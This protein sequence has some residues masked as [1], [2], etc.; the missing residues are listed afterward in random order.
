MFAGGTIGM[1]EDKKTGVLRPA[2]DVSAILRFFPELRKKISF[3][4]FSLFNIDSSNMEPSHWSIV[5]RKIK[6]VYDRFDGFLVI[7]GT[8]TLAYTASALSFAL[9]NLSKPIVFTGSLVPLSELGADARNNLIYASL[10]AT[11]DIAEVCIVFGHKILRGNRSKKN[12]ESFV[13]VFDSPI[14]PQL[15]EIERPIRL[16]EW[17]RKRRKRILA[18][19]PKFET[20][21]RLVKIF[22]GFDPSSLDRMIQGGAKG[23]I[24]E[25]YGPGN[26]PFLENSILP[27]IERAIKNG[28][29]VV[30]GSQMEKSVTN[31]HAYEAGYKVLQ[32][33]AISA[34]DMT[35]ESTVAKLMWV[36]AQTRDIKKVKALMENDLAGELSGEEG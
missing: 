15:G 28:I 21:I 8:D 24:I 32:L 23:L 17:R 18:Y 1:V 16:H 30:I 29:P 3:E 27:Q 11:M 22:P 10:V 7:Q 9:R 12:H 35:T 6:E 14:F 31:L 36:L 4:F 20:N 5:A 13:D 19:Q 34:H 33:G 26:I 2:E 25:G